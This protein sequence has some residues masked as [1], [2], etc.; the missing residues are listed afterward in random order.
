[1]TWAATAVG[2]VSAVGSAAGSA[3][4]G[5]KKGSGQSRESAAL[6]RE[7]AETA[8][9]LRE[10]GTAQAKLTQPLRTG[11]VNILDQ[12]LQTG[13]TPGFL[14]LLTTVQ[15]LAALSLPG[16][17]SEQ[18]VLNQRLMSQGNRGGQLQQQLAQAAIQGGIQ[19]SGL[20]QQDLLRQEG[21]DVAR[22]GIRQTLFGAASDMGA[23]GL[24]L[25]M[26]GVGQGMAG[27]GQAAMNMNSLGAQRI[28]ENMAFQQGMGQ[29]AGKA[30]GSLANRYMP[31]YDQG[32]LGAQKMGTQKKTV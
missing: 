29:L 1:M 8:R 5:G 27:L 15:P 10:L 25:G 30:G 2:T 21:R 31:A 6:T 9:V 28:Q 24:S 11:S 4:S 23:G 18:R 14:D 7:Q 13:Q 32:S 20:Q 26:Q 12:F 17:A 16:L 3:A 19:R 22:T